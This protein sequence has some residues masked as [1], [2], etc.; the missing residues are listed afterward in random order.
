MSIGIGNIKRALEEILVEMSG[1]LDSTTQPLAAGA[2]YTGPAFAITKYKTIVGS[3]YSDVA[4]TLRVEQR[5]DGAN[6]DV[7]SEFPYSAGDLMGFTVEVVGNEGRLVFVNG[8]SP[9]TTFRL[10]ARGRKL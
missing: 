3:C 6:W 10:Y 8:S 4:G 7:R 5:N 1:V 9:Q 2:A